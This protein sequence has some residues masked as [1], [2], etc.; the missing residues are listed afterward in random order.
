[1]RAPLVEAAATQGV[2][3]GQVK[4]NALVI[5]SRYRGPFGR[6]D[7]IILD[8]DDTPVTFDGVFGM[9]EEFYLRA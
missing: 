3:G 7:G 4:V 2:A 8:R 6:L 1:M 5:E 9:G